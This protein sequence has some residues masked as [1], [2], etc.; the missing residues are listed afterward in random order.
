MKINFKQVSK[1]V[2]MVSSLLLS[3]GG[4][5][6][7]TTIPA[8]LLVAS[9][10]SS[11]NGENSAVN[12]QSNAG[13]SDLANSVF[14]IEPAA[15]PELLDEIGTDHASQIIDTSD[16]GQPATGNMPQGNT[17]LASV[18]GG[19]DGG[20]IAMPNWP[21]SPGNSPPVYGI[22]AQP[23]VV[24]PA[25]NELVPPQNSVLPVK[26]EPKSPVSGCDAPKDSDTKNKN[27]ASSDPE[28]KC[29]ENMDPTGDNSP[30]ANI[31]PV[32]TSVPPAQNV[33]SEI[34]DGCGPLSEKGPAWDILPGTEDSNSPGEQ[35]APVMLPGIDPFN[36]P[37]LD[38]G[39]SGGGDSPFTR[40]MPAEIIE[41][42]N[43]PVSMGPDDVDL[44]ASIP[45]ID[46]PLISLAQ[47][48]V[49]QVPEPAILSLMGGGLLG[50]GWFRR[51]K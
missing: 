36:G 20:P 41:P 7:A 32:A 45:E 5:V 44:P 10:V 38:P 37:F 28:S 2:G 50:L 17:V 8:A 39:V 26:D 1:F 40:E 43:I 35:G 29:D 19:N 16:N 4:K 22:P 34:C 12:V 23:G 13:M 21:Q 3:P 9:M 25:P 24:T 15:S 11:N 48:Q 27:V 14:G 49:A 30:E 6:A 33:P 18:P 42:E 46:R 31:P 51:R 47:P